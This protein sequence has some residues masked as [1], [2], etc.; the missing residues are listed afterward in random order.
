MSAT[1]SI[2]DEQAIYSANKSNKLP[3]FF[4]RPRPRPRQSVDLSSIILPGNLSADQV[5]GHNVDSVVDQPVRHVAKQPEA[6]KS[7]SLKNVTES[8]ATAARCS[9]IPIRLTSSAAAAAGVNTP[10]SL[11]LS[12]GT[13]LRVFLPTAKCKRFHLKKCKCKCNK[14]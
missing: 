9:H 2:S 11:A 5:S 1:R 4:P 6:K 13:K 7:V 3:K 12:P 10:N 8:S 14:F